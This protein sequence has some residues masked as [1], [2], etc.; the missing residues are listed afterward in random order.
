MNDHDL[1]WEDLKKDL[2]D[3]E[4]LLE[5]LQVSSEVD[6]MR[7]LRILSGLTQW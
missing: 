6:S 5:Y 2:E 1:Y 7:T 3:P 4:F